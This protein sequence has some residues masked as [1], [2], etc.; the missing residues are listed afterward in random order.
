MA[1]DVA[2]ALGVIQQR[3]GRL[4]DAERAFRV[5]LS[6]KPDTPSALECLGN[7]RLDEGRVAEAMESF[8]SLVAFHPSNPYGHVGVG[9]ALGLEGKVDQAFEELRHASA[10]SPRLEAPYRQ[11]GILHW[12][13][14]D[15]PAAEHAFREA[16]V[17]APENVHSQ[18]YL[19]LTLMRLGQEREA[20]ALYASLCARNPLWPRQTAFSAYRVATREAP[21][22]RLGP[23]ALDLALQACQA[24]G[25]HDPVC[26]EALAAAQ[27][28]L[29]DFDAALAAIDQAIALDASPSA[30]W[31]ARM[32][33]QRDR[34]QARTPLPG[35]SP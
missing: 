13:R 3:R 8:R 29:G 15:L 4:A 1:S 12:R 35:D 22:E 24:T 25:Y 21:G 18:G 23:L 11:M 7:L 9:V 31:T 2:A 30:E 6:L 28:A 16:L 17:R 20:A 10:I 26:L 27:A 14:G 34:L 33:R 19:A 32:A 5:A